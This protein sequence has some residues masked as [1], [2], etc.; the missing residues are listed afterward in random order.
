VWNRSGS[1]RIGASGSSVIVGGNV[2]HVKCKKDAG[3]GCDGSR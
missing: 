3:K 1:G 2:E